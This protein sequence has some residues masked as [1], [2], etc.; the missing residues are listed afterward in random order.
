MPPD[1]PRLRGRG[2]GQAL[3]SGNQAPGQTQ[4]GS[5]GA[6]TGGGGGG[7]NAGSQDGGSGIVIVRY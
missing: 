3:N 5:A 4:G 7:G 2:G 6:N 1:F